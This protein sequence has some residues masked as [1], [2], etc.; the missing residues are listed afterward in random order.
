MLYEG[1]TDWTAK[2]YEASIGCLRTLGQREED[3]IRTYQEM[4]MNEKLAAT[5]EGKRARMALNKM[6]PEGGAQ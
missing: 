6:L 1:Y 2:A 5:P 3:I 4:L